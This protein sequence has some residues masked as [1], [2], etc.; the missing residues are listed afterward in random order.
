MQCLPCASPN[1]VRFT[2]SSED[3]PRT[4]SQDSPRIYCKALDISPSNVSYLH[5]S[6]LHVTYLY[7]SYL[8]VSYLLAVYPVM[9]Y[10]RPCLA[11]LQHIRRTLY[12]LTM[13]VSLSRPVSP[14][15]PSRGSDQIIRV[16]PWIMDSWIQD[17]CTHG[18]WVSSPI[19]HTPD[20]QL[21]TQHP[22]LKPPD[23][24]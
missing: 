4:R 12:C 21:K 6:Y 22:Q 16:S 7:V 10:P 9:S 11:P 14:Q 19:D 2:I 24:A 18:S 1:I 3:Q 20:P 17:L 13:N 5:V 8:H 15:T 23:P